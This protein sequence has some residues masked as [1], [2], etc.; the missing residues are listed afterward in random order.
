MS[1]HGDG[2]KLKDNTLPCDL[3]L[4]AIQEIRG[5]T[6]SVKINYGMFGAEHSAMKGITSMRN[7]TFWHLIVFLQEVLQLMSIEKLFSRFVCWLKI[8]CESVV[9]H[10]PDAIQVHQDVIQCSSLVEP[11]CIE[12]SLPMLTKT[13]SQ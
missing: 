9:F 8:G 10:A 5:R 1:S 13:Q 6:Q 11:S 3:L 2:N 7:Y 4:D 12:G